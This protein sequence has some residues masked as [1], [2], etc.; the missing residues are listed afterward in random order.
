MTTDKSIHE[1]INAAVQEERERAAA[2]GRER[3]PRSTSTSASH[4]SRASSTSS[5][6]SAPAPG[7][8]RR[9]TR[10][11]PRQGASRERSRGLPPVTEAVQGS[12]DSVEDAPEY[13]FVIVGSGPVAV[14]SRPTSPRRGSPSPSSR[15]AGTTSA[16]TTTPP[17]CRPMRAKTPTWCGTSPSPHYDDPTRGREDSKWDDDLGGILYPRGSTLGGG[18]AVSAMVHIAPRPRTG[19]DSRSSPAMR[20]GGTA[21]CGRSSSASRTGRASTPCRAR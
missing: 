5:G 19:T 1:Q 4:S 7:R 14:R 2:S 18:T 10:S 6:T 11:Q 15:P 20:A 8:A 3:S 13:D 21:R 9:R 17:S 12:G 16:G